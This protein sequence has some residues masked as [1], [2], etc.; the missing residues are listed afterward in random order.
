[1]IP[2]TT[3]KGSHEW[4]EEYK[5]GLFLS[6]DACVMPLRIANFCGDIIIIE[7]TGIS[8]DGLLDDS[9]CGKGR[10]FVWYL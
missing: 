10:L 8:Y 3:G 2:K 7:A 4:K 9:S 1:M 6:C 5:N